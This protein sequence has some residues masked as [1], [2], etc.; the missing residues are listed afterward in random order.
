MQG[1]QIKRVEAGVQEFSQCGPIGGY[2]SFGQVATIQGGEIQ[3]PGVGG[4]VGIGSGFFEGADGFEKSC[5]YW[6]S[7]LYK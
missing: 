2:G 3:A 5:L 1:T 7:V 6:A 4:Q